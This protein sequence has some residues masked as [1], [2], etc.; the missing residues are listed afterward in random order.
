V[1]DVQWFCIVQLP[2]TIT[3]NIK[4]LYSNTDFSHVKNFFQNILLN[5]TWLYDARLQ[6]YGVINFVLFF[7]PRCTSICWKAWSTVPCRCPWYTAVFNMCFVG[8]RCRRISHLNDSVHGEI[9]LWCR[10]M[11][12][13]FPGRKTR[14]TYA[15][16]S[17]TI[18]STLPLPATRS[19]TRQ[20]AATCSKGQVCSTFPPALTT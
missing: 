7:G 11:L 13:L 19:S 10:E 14:S 17:T 12:R 20:L 15:G 18:V 8:C 5:T 6:N 16:H 4:V 3:K 9:S 1:T 2:A